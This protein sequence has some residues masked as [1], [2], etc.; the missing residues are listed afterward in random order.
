MSAWS[1]D[2]S[3]APKDK[4]IMF[5][6]PDWEC[7]VIVYWVSEHSWSG[8]LLL[9]HCFLMFKEKLTKKIILI[10]NGQNYLYE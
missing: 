1:K 5:K 4:Q 7:P 8:W 3:Q 9:S 10:S 2:L 6:H